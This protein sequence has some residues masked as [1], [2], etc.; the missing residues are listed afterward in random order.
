[1]SDWIHGE[2]GGYLRHCTETRNWFETDYPPFLEEAGSRSILAARTDEHASHIIEAL[3]TG[4]RLSRPFQRQ[5]Q[6][7]HRPICR[8][9]RSSRR[10]ASSI[11]SGST[12]RPASCLP[13]ACAAT[14]DGSINVQRMAIERRSRATSICSSS[15][16]CTIRW[17]ARS[18][19]PTKSGRWS[20]KC[21]SL[22][23]DGS[24]NT[25]HA[26]DAAKQGRLCPRR[27]EDGAARALRA[28]PV[29]SVEE[30]RAANAPA[31]RNQ[32]QNDPAVA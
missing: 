10:R 28:R 31:K 32:S 8:R 2:T 14:C 29:R 17:S 7:R 13:L 19:R 18:A 20:T 9:T 5:E 11:V 4:P 23:R 16:C 1:M 15:R 22:R 12:W 6:R 3:E 27:R 24:R 30:L 26:I 25:Q 21:W